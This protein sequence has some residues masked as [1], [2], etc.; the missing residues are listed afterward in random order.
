MNEKSNL[1]KVP[2][3]DDEQL[4]PESVDMCHDDLPPVIRPKTVKTV[5]TRFVQGEP[6]KPLPWSDSDD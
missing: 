5:R 3:A 1:N 6:L 2:I 4:D